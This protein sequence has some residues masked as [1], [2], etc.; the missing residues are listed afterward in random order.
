MGPFTESPVTHW[1][2]WQGASCSGF[3]ACAAAICDT[4]WFTHSLGD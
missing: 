1:I 4:V 2:S 3:R